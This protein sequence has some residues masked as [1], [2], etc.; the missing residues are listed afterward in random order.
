MLVQK[1]I[2]IFFQ[3][4]VLLFGFSFSAFSFELSVT[5]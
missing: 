5:I 2:E 1:M 3:F 4:F